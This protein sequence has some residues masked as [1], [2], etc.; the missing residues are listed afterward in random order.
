[1]PGL[2]AVL[3]GLC[4]SLLSHPR[5]LGG[6]YRFLLCWL[7]CGY[8]VEAPLD[9]FSAPDNPRATSNKIVADDSDYLHTQQRTQDYLE[10]T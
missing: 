5:S 1:V 9:L 10:L 4:G 2:A 3:F 7:R 8:P 6:P